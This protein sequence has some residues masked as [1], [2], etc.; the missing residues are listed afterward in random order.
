LPIFSLIARSSG[1]PLGLKGFSAAKGEGWL[2]RPAPDLDVASAR[3]Q[4]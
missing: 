3:K 4:Y 2:Q 1:D